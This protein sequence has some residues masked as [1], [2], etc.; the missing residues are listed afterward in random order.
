MALKALL[1]EESSV[2]LLQIVSVMGLSKQI[3]SL[4]TQ[5]LQ[6]IQL[7]RG[8]GSDLVFEFQVSQGDRTPLEYAIA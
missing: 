7:P 8:F 3:I 5:Y 2:S 1:K 6:A 4:L